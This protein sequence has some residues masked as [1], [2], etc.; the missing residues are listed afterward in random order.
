MTVGLLRSIDDVIGDSVAARRMNFV[1]VSSFA[2]VA[3]VLTAAGLYGVMAY[4]VAQRTREIGV[5][6]ALGASR[7]QVLGLMIRQGGSMT[8]VGIALGIAGAL[9]M[10]RF[11]T[12][13]L[14]GISAA[15][16]V[17]YLAVS[18]LLSAVACIAIA[19]PSLRA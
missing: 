13:L 9:L 18:A 3:V 14:F 15:D 19:V 8:V 4:I 5:R 10:T 17:V 16:P 12:S 7:G 1:L 11:M 2:I 6:M